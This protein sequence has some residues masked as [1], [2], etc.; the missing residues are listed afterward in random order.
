M[1]IFQFLPR[2]LV[3][4]SCCLVAAAPALGQMVYKSVGADG[5]VSYGDRPPTE[6]Q[7][8]MSRSFTA[9]P[10]TVLPVSMV[11]R[12]RK[13]RQSAGTPAPAVGGV[14]LYSA[15]WCGYCTKAKAYLDAKR[16]RYSEV[17]I[18]TE[19]GLASFSQAG[20]GKGV[21]LLVAGDKRIQGFSVASYDA[22]F[23]KGP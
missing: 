23:G 3:L 9:A 21:P 14:V 11:E 18:D 8:V 6:G 13:F 17:D 12:L 5:K 2:C 15:A 4:L 16:I 1:T 19:A 10:S 20:G 22:L 7:V